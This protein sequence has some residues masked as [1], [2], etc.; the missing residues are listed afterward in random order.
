MGKDSYFQL[1]KHPKWQ[2]K[3]LSI[4]QR[5]EFQCEW[6]ASSDYTLHVHHTYYERGAK[7]WEYP[8]DS[9]LCLCEFCHGR[10]HRLWERLKKVI[11]KLMAGTDGEDL[12]RVLGYGKAVLADRDR[13]HDRDSKIPPTDVYEAFGIGDYFKLR[14]D[15]VVSA[16]IA[17]DDGLTAEELW[18]L[19]REWK[20]SSSSGGED[21]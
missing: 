1:L 17:S 4:M 20:A 2:E 16:L 18:R 6:C 13:L 9:L 14:M 10:A 11:G 8:D 15:L 3:R 12:E 5:A 21:T 19:S 7:P